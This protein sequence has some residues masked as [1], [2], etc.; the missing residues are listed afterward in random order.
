MKRHLSSLFFIIF[1]SLT[2]SASAG[3]KEVQDRLYSLSA[4]DEL[5][6]HR[7]QKWVESLEQ[8]LARAK[9]ENKFLL[10]AFVGTPWC[11]WSEK[12]ETEVLS[13][14]DFV[15]RVS[16]EFV[17]VSVTL[18]DESDE[19]TSIK[20]QFAI[21]ELPTL[22]VA[23]P[24]GKEITRVGFLPKTPE[25]F[26]HHLTKIRRDYIEVKQVVDREDLS[27][28]SPKEIQRLYLKAKNQGFF[29]LKERLFLAGLQV[30]QGLF[31]LLEQY[32]SLAEKGKQGSQ[33]GEAVRKKICKL[34]PKNEQG[35]Y[36]SLALLE[37]EALSQRRLTKKRQINA[38]LKPV[39]DYVKKFGK[40]DTENLWKMELLIA[41]FLY[42][43]S[44]VKDALLHAKSAYN[45]APEENK[46]EIV[47]TIS[48]LETK[49]KKGE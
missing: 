49:V 19:L 36:R 11:P 41:Q 43:K 6:P 46:A 39:I 30:D 17:M 1:S 37:F 5:L 27:M 13:E 21:E 7:H 4:K 16:R 18:K 44:R 9:E 32:R 48:Y 12:I 38:A 3:L 34:D 47:D 25:A 23:D 8:G 2:I 40:E 42:R 14:H 29:A 26:A 20:E 10:I 33:E 28:F 22:I 45:H 15:S 35:A 31:F 24:Q